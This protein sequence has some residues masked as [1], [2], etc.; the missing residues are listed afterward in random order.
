MS[1]G[2]LFPYSGI[3]CKRFCGVPDVSSR[4]ASLWLLFIPSGWQGEPLILGL[5]LA[6]CLPLAQFTLAVLL[7]LAVLR[8]I[9]YSDSLIGPCID[10][11][12]CHT[13]DA[14]DVM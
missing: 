3:V 1:G 5:S 8:L 4:P 10:D 9:G 14:L 11:T 12:G 6:L 2:M 13:V 7:W